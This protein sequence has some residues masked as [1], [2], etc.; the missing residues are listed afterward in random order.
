MF[1]L[2]QSGLCESLPRS[3]S[4]FSREWRRF[5]G[6]SGEKYAFLLRLGG[7][8]LREMFRTEVGFELL[9][10]FLMV[11]CECFRPGDEAAVIG[12][13]HGLSL[14]GRFSLSVA[15]LSEEERG[16]CER[17][18]YKLL[19]ADPNLADV[20][21]SQKQRSAERETKTEENAAQD[22]GSDVAGKLRGLMAKYG[23]CENAK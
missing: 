12:V 8:N 10:E 22:D 9:G 19:E 5:K 11:A 3:V 13:L 20:P 14:T 16:A 23:V 7:E 18:F 6:S 1:L 4:E 17:L 15:L 2:F 21:E